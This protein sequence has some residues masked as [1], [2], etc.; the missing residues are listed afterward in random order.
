V[1]IGGFIG[2][3]L[4]YGISSFSIKYFGTSFP[5]GTLIVNV[6]GCFIIGFILNYSSFDIQPNIKLLIITGLLGALTTFSTFSY[7]TLTFFDSNQ[8][9]LGISNIILNLLLTMLSVF[10]GKFIA[11]IL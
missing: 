4:R 11:S 3:V 5:F 10:A 7:E 9:L 1:G 8:Y 2:A 6:I